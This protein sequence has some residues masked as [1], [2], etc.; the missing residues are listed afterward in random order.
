MITATQ[1]VW[2]EIMKY[3]ASINDLEMWKSAARGFNKASKF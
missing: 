3:A 2:L 1:S